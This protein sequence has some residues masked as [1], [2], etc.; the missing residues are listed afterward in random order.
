M[1]WGLSDC[2]GSYWRRMNINPRLRTVSTSPPEKSVWLCLSKLIY[3]NATSYWIPLTDGDMTGGCP[4]ATLA[5]ITYEAAKS[6]LQNAP[7]MVNLTD[8]YAKNRAC[9]RTFS[10]YQSMMVSAQWSW[11]SCLPSQNMGTASVCRRQQDSKRQADNWGT[12]ERDYNVR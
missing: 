11:W 8:L 12:C 5:H 7:P 1:F 2:V 4:M 3:S 6:A 9:D 10:R